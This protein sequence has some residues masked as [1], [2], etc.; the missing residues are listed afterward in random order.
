MLSKEEFKS[1]IPQYVEQANQLTDAVI[2][3]ALEHPDADVVL[4]ARQ[5]KAMYTIGDRDEIRDMWHADPEERRRYTFDAVVPLEGLHLALNRRPFSS[6]AWL[7]RITTAP[8][9]VMVHDPSVEG[10]LR[11][12]HTP[13]MK[14]VAY[15]PPNL[16]SPAF[17]FRPTAT[18]LPPEKSPLIEVGVHG[19]ELNGDKILQYRQDAL[20]MTTQ[21]YADATYPPLRP[22]DARRLQSAGVYGYTA[23]KIAHQMILLRNVAND[24]HG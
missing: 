18:E 7:L 4:S 12:L 24:L 6:A 13:G 10:K 16:I 14:E 1:Q 2:N 5:D 8:E 21:T 20:D 17:R 22:A 19:P 3:G 11:P 15:H 23:A 9:P